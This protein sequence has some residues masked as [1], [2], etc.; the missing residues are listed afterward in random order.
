MG[1]PMGRTL[2]IL[3]PCA[4]GLI[5]AFLVSCG[6]TSKLIPGDDAAAINSNVDAAQNASDTGRC[7]RASAA[8]DRAQTHVEQLPS[9]V[10]PKLRADLE[11]GL[12]RLRAAAASECTTNRTESA[13]TETTATTEST[14]STT[15]TTESTET[16]NTETQN[17]Q[18]ETQPTETQNTETQGG[19]TTIDNGGGGSGG[20]SDG[21]SGGTPAP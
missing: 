17:T 7:E 16:Q 5:A 14:E 19:G 3:L 2:R 13:T 11:Q 8:V 9:S 15:A 18:T 21:G 4:L 6:D 10:D 12:A 1:R 20:T